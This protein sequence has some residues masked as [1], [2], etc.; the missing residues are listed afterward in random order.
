MPRKL[1]MVFLKQLVMV[2]HEKKSQ[3]DGRLS[4]ESSRVLDA[5]GLCTLSGVC[6]IYSMLPVR[7]VALC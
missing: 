4:R 7:C 5:D 1:V 3:R 2:E 6:A